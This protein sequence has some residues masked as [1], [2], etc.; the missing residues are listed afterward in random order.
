MTAQIFVYDKHNPIFTQFQ[1]FKCAKPLQILTLNITKMRYLF[2]IWVGIYTY[3]YVT[4][5]KLLC[6][7]KTINVLGLNFS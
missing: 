6:Y 3:T 7:E 2:V 4:S 5:L 1:R